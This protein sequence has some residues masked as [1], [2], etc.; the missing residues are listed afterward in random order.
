MIAA[1]ANDGVLLLTFVSHLEKTEKFTPKKAVIRA[2]MLRLRPIVMTTVLV[3]VS[4]I[5]LVLNL[6]WGGEMLQP[7]AAAAI[8]GLIFEIMISL[9][10]DAL[11]IL[12]FYEKQKGGS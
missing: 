1:L 8:G 5:P 7:M 10:F 4:F 3:I 2:G 9:F 11:P 6:G 12:C